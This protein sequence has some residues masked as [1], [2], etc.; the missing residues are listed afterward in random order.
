MRLESM[1]DFYGD[2]EERELEKSEEI[3]E[4]KIEIDKSE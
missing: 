1:Y 3:P 4:E 2:K